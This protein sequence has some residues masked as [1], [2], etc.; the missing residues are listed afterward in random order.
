MLDAFSLSNGVGDPAEPLTQGRHST[1]NLKGRVIKRW[2]YP[3]LTS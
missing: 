2:L 3:F 1:V